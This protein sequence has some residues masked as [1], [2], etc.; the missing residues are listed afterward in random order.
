MLIR[1]SKA[2]GT[3]NIYKTH[4][5][6]FRKW[7]KMWNISPYIN[8]SDDIYSYFATHRFSTTTNV[9]ATISSCVSGVIST[10]NTYNPHIA[11]DRSKQG[12]T[13]STLKG[14]KRQ[15]GRQSR[16]TNPLR[17]QILIHLINKYN[18]FT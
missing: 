16:S 15:P 12:L 13:N 18:K 14:I 5:K 8:H 3:W 6:H 4:N 11:I 9:H 7:C 10:F 17:N 2:E 1:S